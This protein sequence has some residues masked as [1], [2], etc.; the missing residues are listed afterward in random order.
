MR[1]D[2]CRLTRSCSSSGISQISFEISSESELCAVMGEE[3]GVS[4][5]CECADELRDEGGGDLRTNDLRHVR[6]PLVGVSV[7][8]DR[9]AL[10]FRSL[11]GWAE[12]TGNEGDD[13][14]TVVDV[15]E[16]SPSSWPGTS[17]QRMRAFLDVSSAANS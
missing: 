17:A 1:N 12:D 2:H 7:V 5:R 15:L 8:V 14:A 4:I 16:T 9:R 3:G 13:T 10:F 6:A 11:L